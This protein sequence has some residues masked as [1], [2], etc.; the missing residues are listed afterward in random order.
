M[1]KSA[2]KRGTAGVL[3][4]VPLLGLPQEV[5]SSS[6]LSRDST[7]HSPQRF[8]GVGAFSAESC[9]RPPRFQVRIKST[10]RPAGTTWDL[11]TR[12]RM[13]PRKVSL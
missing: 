9:S 2:R 12:Y 11:F 1:G 7:Q 13:R 5:V 8:R 4:A 3:G 10:F 6:A